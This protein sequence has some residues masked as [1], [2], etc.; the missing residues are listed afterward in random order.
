MSL[1][2]RIFPV[3]LIRD[4]GLVK[5]RKF[6]EDRYV[7]DPMNAVKI[8]N[9]KEVDELAIYDIDATTEGRGPMFERLAKIAVESRMPLSYG[10][11]VR[12]AEDAA[13]LVSIGYEKVSVSAAAVER[14]DLV[15]E[16]ARRVGR[17]SV[18]V[19]VDVK[20][21]GLLG[22]Y[23]VYTHNGTRKHKIKPLDFIAQ[24]VE[25]GAGE[26]VVNSIDRDGMMGGYDLK[27]AKSVRER[28]DVPISFVG[29]AGSTDDME[30]LIRTVGTVGAGAGSIFV[31]KGPYRAVLISYARPTNVSE[32]P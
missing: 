9:E 24:V 30:E 21:E 25:L 5:T 20:R 12:S 27:F 13:R 11:G 28:V 1:K 31:F 32:G 4:Q 18:V 15:A 29:G 26:I 14:S 3:L 6:G 7:G 17:Q 8:F 22:N 19:T 16:M 2:S 10:G 23:S